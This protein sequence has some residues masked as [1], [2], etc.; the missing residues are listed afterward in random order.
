MCPEFWVHI[1]IEKLNVGIFLK[2]KASL[3]ECFIDGRE[4]FAQLTV[5]KQVEV[6]LLI[7]DWKTSSKQTVDMTALGGAAKAGYLTCSRK[8]VSSRQS[9][10]EAL[11]IEQ[12]VTGLWSKTTDL[13]TV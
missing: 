9:M 4:K 5:D 8:L 2:R 10:D 13:L 11:L 3:I 12:S 6:L 7:F 1:I